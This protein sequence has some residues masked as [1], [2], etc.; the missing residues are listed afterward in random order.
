MMAFATIFFNEKKIF[1][2]DGDSNKELI[3]PFQVD[4]YNKFVS[5]RLL[6]LIQ[7]NIIDAGLEIK[8]V[9]SDSSDGLLIPNDIY[10][11]EKREGF[12]NLN[13]SSVPAG[14]ILLENELSSLNATMVYSCKK[15]FYDFF[16]T[17]F[18]QV[19]LL[20]STS[21]YLNKILSQREGNKDIHIVIKNNTFDVIKLKNKKLF[22]YNSIEFSSMTD[23]I[24]F[25]I[26]HI[27]KLNIACPSVEVYG[28]EDQLKELKLI[29]TK[30]KTLK[31]NPFHFNSN[32]NF[33]DL[34]K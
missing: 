1:V 2:L 18:E 5:N 10:S 16:K 14:K 32:T 22:S 21:Q 33:I 9:I 28:N 25:L 3:E 20:H 4:S 26:G 7:A 30:I 29:K 11:P 6:N 19:P 12:Y 23:I 27:N 17:H 15:W 13:Y 31:D 34:I 24:Y 8:T